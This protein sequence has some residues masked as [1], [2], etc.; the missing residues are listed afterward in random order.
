MNVE[1]DLDRTLT[2][3]RNKIREKGFTQLEV[4]N[5]L[6]WGRS[7]IS[8]LLTKQKSLRVE[9][10]LLILDVIGVE[11][12]EFYSELYRFSTNDAG[13]RN[14]DDYI[15]HSSAG[16]WR[17]EEGTAPALQELQHGHRELRA[18][19]RGLVRVL[20]DKKICDVRELNEAMRDGGGADDEPH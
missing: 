13:L 3:L 15:E 7:Y 1:K 14:L 4:Q 20:I 10:I 17:G 12:A 2:L 8:Q 18:M 6:N 11:P 5:A 16:A 19:V 9:Q